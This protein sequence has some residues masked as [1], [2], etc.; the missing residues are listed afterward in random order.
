MSLGYAVKMDGWW[1]VV[2]V[3]SSRKVN[4]RSP[5]GRSQGWRTVRHLVYLDGFT[6]DRP[7]FTKFISS[8]SRWSS[9]EKLKLAVGEIRQ[10]DIESLRDELRRLQETQ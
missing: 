3:R 9:I 1:Y 4:R 7:E 2:K 10:R 8:A 6:D 5:S